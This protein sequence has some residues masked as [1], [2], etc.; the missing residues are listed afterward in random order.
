MGFFPSAHYRDPHTAELV[1]VAE[2]RG[3]YSMVASKLL[4]MH[5]DYLQ[6]YTC[7]MPQVR[8]VKANCLALLR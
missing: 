5:A 7:S 4:F 6:S 2:P 3:E 1:F 8:R